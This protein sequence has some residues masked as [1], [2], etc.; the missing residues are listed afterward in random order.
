MDENTQI[1]MPNDIKIQIEEALKEIKATHKRV[2]SIITPTKYVEKKGQF[3][4]VTAPYV[5]SIA[6]KNYPGWS[7]KLITF[8]IVIV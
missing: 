5:K 3:D 8:Q 1:V 2:G 6:D 7:W 4:Y